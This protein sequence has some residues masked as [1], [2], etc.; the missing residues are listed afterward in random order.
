MLTFQLGKKGLNGGHTNS[1]L[2]GKKYMHTQF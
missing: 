2:S 1:G